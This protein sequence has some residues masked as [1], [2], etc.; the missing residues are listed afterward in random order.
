MNA[1]R[2]QKYGS[3]TNTKPLFVSLITV[4]TDQHRAVYWQKFSSKP[5]I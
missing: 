5:L 4:T 1:L 2:I 3:N